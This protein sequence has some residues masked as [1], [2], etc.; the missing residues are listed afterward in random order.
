MSSPGKLGFRARGR[1]WRP[2]VGVIMVDD[3]VD[4]IREEAKED[5]MHVGGVRGGGLYDA[6][7][8]IGAAWRP[9]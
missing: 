5:V 8:D 4:V 7:I 2:L 9:S 6:V 1:R 3:V